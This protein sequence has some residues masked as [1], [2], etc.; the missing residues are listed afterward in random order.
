ME[1]VARAPAAVL[2]ALVVFTFG[3]ASEPIPDPVRETARTAATP[4]VAAPANSCLQSGRTTMVRGDCP[5]DW[6]GETVRVYGSCDVT[7]GTT[8]AGRPC[9]RLQVK[10]TSGDC[11][12]RPEA[13]T[14]PAV[15]IERVI[16]WIR[17]GRPGAILRSCRELDA[18]LLKNSVLHPSGRG[19]TQ[20]FARKRL[21]GQLPPCRLFVS[22]ARLAIAE[23]MPGAVLR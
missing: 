19:G 13:V 6:D 5:V 3:C 8:S 17:E 18:T 10:A 21:L 4:E 9:L 1:T 11:I 7:P 22:E 16:L 20:S 12:V 23:A 2:V 14:T 15:S